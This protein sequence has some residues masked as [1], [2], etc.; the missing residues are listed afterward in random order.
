MYG[1]GSHPVPKWNIR[2]TFGSRGGGGG[3]GGGALRYIGGPHPCTYFAEEGVFIKNSACPRFCKSRVLF[4]TQVRSMGDEN[5]LTI[6]EIYM[7][8]T[9]SDSRSDWASECA[10]AKQA[11]D[12]KI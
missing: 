10:A 8:L 6:H 9:P 7:V 3:G 12:Y 1:L 11:E 4:C 5:P 2:I